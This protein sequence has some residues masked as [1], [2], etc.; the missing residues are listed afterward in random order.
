MADCSR[1]HPRS[2]YLKTEVSCHGQNPRFIQVD[3]SIYFN[4]Q[5]ILRSGHRLYIQFVH[6]TLCTEVKR[7]EFAVIFLGC[8][9]ESIMHRENIPLVERFP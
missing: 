9:K 1:I 7:E 8:W 5:D 6:C 3:S 2:W 4:V